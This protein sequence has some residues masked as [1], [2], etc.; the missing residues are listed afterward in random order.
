MSKS[1]AEDHSPTQE[2]S[3]KSPV[4]PTS[5]ILIAAVAMIAAAVIGKRTPLTPGTAEAS[6][7]I[8][9]T[10]PAAPGWPAPPDQAAIDAALNYSVD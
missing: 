9:T 1:N 4:I 10:K 8:V 5:I 6:P 7:S 3:M 2:V